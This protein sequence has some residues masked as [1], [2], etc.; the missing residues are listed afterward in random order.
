MMRRWHVFFANWQNI[1]ALLIVGTYIVVAALAPRLAPPEDPD[2]PVMFQRIPGV[3][4][5]ALRKPRP[6]SDGVPL[7]ATSGGWNVFYSLVWG[8]RHALRFGLLVTVLTGSFGV[9][10]GAI[11]GYSGGRVSRLLMRITDAFLTFPAI[12]G[13][14]FFHQILRSTDP[15]ATSLL[16]KVML[17]LH[18]DPVM[19]ALIMFSWMPYTRMINANVA[20]LKQTEYAMAATTVGVRKLR[21]IFRH[22]LPN[23]VAP[24]MVL[25]ARDIGGMVVLEAAFT[26]IGVGNGSPWGALL[27]IG[28]DWII[29]PGG[30]LLMYWWV[31]LPPTLALVLFSIGW[32]LLGDGLNIFLNPWLSRGNGKA[33]W[34][35]F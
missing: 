30:N 10:I 11:S 1:L 29:G 12:A 26:Y 8:T 32:N 28:R 23:A 17:F 34:R 5:T 3:R 35:G 33:A 7:G 24:A 2:D 9:V 16:Q 13:V 19:L 6:P 31:F 27:I 25:A 14:F 4:V 18:M 21:I 20:R 15:Q 22:L